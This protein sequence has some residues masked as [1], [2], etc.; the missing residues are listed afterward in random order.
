V[1]DLASRL[2]PFVDEDYCY[3]STRGRVT[4]RPHEIEIWF[5][6]DGTTLYLLAGGRERSDWVRNLVAQSAVTVRVGPSTY[7]GTAR[8]VDPDTT[9]DEHARALV[10]A[11]YSPTNGDLTTWRDAAL[12]VAVDLHDGARPS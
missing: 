5:A 1:D 7:A 10:F 3:L 4:D 11:K 2:A 6:L 12:P 8:V 9:E